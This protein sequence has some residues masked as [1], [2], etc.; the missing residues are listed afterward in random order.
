MHG[1][2]TAMDDFARVVAGMTSPAGFFSAE[3]VGLILATAA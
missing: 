1:N 3:N 2:Q